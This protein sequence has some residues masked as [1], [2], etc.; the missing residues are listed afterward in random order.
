[1]SLLRQWDVVLVP[2]PMAN[3]PHYLVLLSPDHLA[4]NEDFRN[5][6]G[7]VCSTIRPPDRPVRTHEVFLNVADGFE[8]RTACRCHLVIEFARED[9]LQNRG[10]VSPARQAAIKRKLR[11]IFGL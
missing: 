3:N 8:Q 4:G 6:N 1:V 10:R 9:I 11:D 2:Y 7:L 5:L